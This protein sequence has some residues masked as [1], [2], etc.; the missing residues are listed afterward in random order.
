MCLDAR[1]QTISRAGDQSP[2]NA[3]CI[4]AR[5]IRRAMVDKRWLAFLLGLGQGDPGLD[6]ID[7]ATVAAQRLEALRMG[8]AA[9][10]D[11]PVDLAG[12]DRLFR[13]D[14]VAVRDFA[15]EQIGNGR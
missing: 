11:H 6:C 12:S 2:D 7:P 8:D 5:H 1:A 9:P 13:A 10:R 4:K 14:A 15:I 3:L